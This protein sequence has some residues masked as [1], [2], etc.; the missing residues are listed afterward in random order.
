MKYIMIHFEFNSE[1][2]EYAT[3]D[4]S[5]R[6][7]NIFRIYMKW[8]NIVTPYEIAPQKMQ[9]IDHSGFSVLE[10]GGQESYFKRNMCRFPPCKTTK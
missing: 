5:P 2:D 8:E 10:W 3:F 9:S 4:I 6:P 7:D 1:C